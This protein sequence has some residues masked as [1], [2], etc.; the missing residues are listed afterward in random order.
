MAAL[1]AWDTERRKKRRQKKRENKAY[2]YLVPKPILRLKYA[3]FLVCFAVSCCVEAYLAHEE[4]S[5]LLVLEQTPCL[6]T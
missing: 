5:L 4:I 6:G 3:V 2:I 1:G